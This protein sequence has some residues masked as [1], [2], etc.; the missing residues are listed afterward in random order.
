MGAFKG[1][2]SSSDSTSNGS[3]MSAVIG[4]QEW[5][6]NP[7]MIQATYTNGILAVGGMDASSTV[8]IQLRIVNLTQPGTVQ[9]AAGQPHSALLYENGAVYSATGVSGTATI[10]V[11]TLT[12]TKAEG[13]FTFSGI[14]TTT[15][16]QRI[17][18][19]GKFSV[20][21]N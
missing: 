10:T 16:L 6:A 21:F 8:Q 19:N 7:T 12:A 20:R 13:T 5:T 11:S 17:V 9:I 1:C 3:T 4:T 18:T 14:N 15:K 2:S